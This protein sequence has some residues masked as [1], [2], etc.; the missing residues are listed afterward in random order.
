[1]ELVKPV[2]RFPWMISRNTLR[3]G[4]F[5]HLAAPRFERKARTRCFGSVLL[6]NQTEEQNLICRVLRATSRFMSAT[7]GGIFKSFEQSNLIRFMRMF[8]S[9]WSNTC[10]GHLS[11]EPHSHGHFSTD[12][13]DGFWKRKIDLRKH[14]NSHRKCIDRTMSQEADAFN[15]ANYA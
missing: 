9:D 5:G 12:S 6:C 2:P 1:M 14:Q 3:H 8:Y 11:N 10:C 4:F 7:G 13:D 15:V